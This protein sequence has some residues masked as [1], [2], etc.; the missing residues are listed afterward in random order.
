[1]GTDD[2]THLIQTNQMASSRG[3]SDFY[4]ISGAMVDDPSSD[5][6]R[7]NYPFGLWLFG[8]TIAKITGLPPITADFIFLIPFLLILLGS[9]YVYSSLWLKSKERKILALLFL[10]SM[11]QI[12][13]ILLS[14]WP[15][16]FVLP[17][18]FFTLFFFLK[19]PVNWK[20][21]PFAWLSIFIIVIGHTGTFLFLFSF[22]IAFFLLYCLIWGEFLKP[23]YVVLMST[24]IIYVISIRQFAEIANQYEIKARV[25]LT[26]GNMLATKFNFT[27]PGDLIRVFYDNLL[28]E[29]HFTYVIILGAIIFVTGKFLIFIHQKTASF[30]S[31][32]E[33]MYA[34]S[35]PI[36]NLSHSVVASPIWLGP[37]QV[38]FS[39]VGV[40][41]L[42]NKGKC[43]LI[44]ALLTT[45]LPDLF[46]SSIGVTTATGVLREI[47][48]LVIII[49]ITATLGFWRIVDYLNDPKSKIKTHVSSAIW[50]VVCL[51]II[52]TPILSTTY[53]LPIIA[54]EDYTINGMKWLGENGDHSHNVVGLG[55]RTV[56]IYTNMTT[57]ETHTGRDTTNFINLLKNIYFRSGNQIRSV[58]DIQQDYGVRYILSSEKII[59]GFGTGTEDLTI[60]TNPAL[61]KIY[62]SDDFGIYDISGS[63]ENP[64]SESTLTDT[65]SIKYEDENY[66]I[67]SDYYKITLGKNTPL[68]KRLG[69]PDNDY[70]NNGFLTEDFEITGT[71]LPS[72]GVKINPD[73]L[74]FTT[75]YKD[76]QITYRTILIN[77]QNKVPLGTLLINYTFYPD[78]IKREYTLSN[79][80]VVAQSSSQIIVQYS[81]HSF[82]L[83]KEFVVKNDKTR[84]ERKTVV[85][86]D[87]VTKNMN[88]EDFYLHQ[89]NDGIYITF[90]GISPQPSSI[91]YSGTETNKSSIV[92]SQ[93]TPV[94]PGASFLSTQFISV[95]SESIAKNHIQSREG[96]KLMNYPDGITPIILSG[97]P[98]QQSDSFINENNAAGYAVLTN[99]SIPYSIVVNPSINL[100]ELGK[101]NTTLIGSQK[102]GG[103]YF[104]DYATQE[105]NLKILTNTTKNQNVS[106]SG[107]MPDSLNYN[108]DTLTILAGNKI[109][110]IFSTQVN[111]TIN[112]E[113]IKGYRT[114][115]IAYVTSKP[116][117]VVLLPISNWKSDILLSTTNPET[118]FSDWKTTIDGAEN[119]D[120]MV[121]LLLRSQDIGNSLYTENFVHL[122][123]YAREKNLTFTSPT[124]IAEHFNQLQN[125]RYSGF[126]E[127]DEASL[128]VTNTNMVTVR[129]VTFKVTLP[130][131][132]EGNYRASDGGIVRIKH[133]NNQ[134]FLYISIEIPPESTKNIIIEPDMQ[135]KTFRIEIPQLPIIEGS[136]A[137]TVKDMAGNPINGAEVFVD[138]DSYQT[139]KNGVIHVNLGRG[140]HKIMVQSPGYEKYSSTIN[141]KGRIFIGQQFINEIFGL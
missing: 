10:I 66:K 76:N 95:G 52:I 57:P 133:E 119:N 123:S 63:S 15:T 110:F 77:P 50:I 121:L 53:Y 82:S 70:L 86:E 88:I 107:F 60:D 13:L 14:Y 21:L 55:L 128:N 65:V 90:A 9:F 64:V 131:L 28:V 41:H 113:Y 116:T 67:A 27:L 102:T 89:D 127:G 134:S 97:Y 91:S 125:I 115:Q 118:I 49:P 138:T 54:G 112:G 31:K 45:I 24:F 101:S 18:L 87:S 22:S 129:N 94:K 98:S 137:I 81:I 103:R 38:I 25:F 117:S 135:R 23:L 17:F 92:I 122:F 11:P 130:A 140:Y 78:V 100:Q 4:K 35:L 69:P 36:Q 108:L 48:Y 56:P 74:E 43:L 26:P 33:S 44:T 20:L 73:D 19:E 42:D 111:P 96:I 68:L 99:N 109:P 71:E 34:F 83:F 6:N 93:S 120:E 39:L 7:F 58:K 59:R 114:P 104:D 105:A 84:L 141:V 8:A 2:Y 1:M 132:A 80:W 12:S 37:M 29:Q 139:D 3:I 51:I 16:T 5:V 75:D 61:S 47:S 62:A 46:N 126:I 40:F 124:R 85:Y 136:N 106:Y 32:N 30:F 72:G 79:D